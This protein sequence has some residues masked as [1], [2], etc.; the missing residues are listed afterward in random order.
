M[1]RSW[2]FLTTAALLIHAVHVP[3]VSCYV[4]DDRHLIKVS[5]DDVVPGG[6]FGY[7]VGLLRSRQSPGR[8]AWVLAGAPKGTVKLL[9]VKESYRT[10]LV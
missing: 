8:Q 6:M 5:N 9:L 10:V 2:R 1:V 3:R 4:F 7:S